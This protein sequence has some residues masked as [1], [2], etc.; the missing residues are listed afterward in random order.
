MYK[1]VPNFLLRFSSPFHYQ[2][3]RIE[4]HPPVIAH[5]LRHQVR[6]IGHQFAL[7]QAAGI[8]GMFPEHP[9]TPGVDGGDDRLI[10]PF[11]GQTQA[12]RAPW[13]LL[14]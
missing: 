10:H 9:V 1:V 2:R 13:P 5:G 12:P 4:M 3:K 8:E 11:G 7:E 6:L 14:R